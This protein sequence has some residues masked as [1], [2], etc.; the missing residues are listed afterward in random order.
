ML[1]KCVTLACE[2]ARAIWTYC[3]RRKAWPKGHTRSM[4]CFA[5]RLFVLPFGGAF[6]RPSESY[7]AAKTGEVSSSRH[8]EQFCK[9]TR[10]Q[11]RARL[12][13]A[14]GFR[15]AW[16]LVLAEE[17]R[18]RAMRVFAGAV[19]ALPLYCEFGRLVPNAS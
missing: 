16:A 15:R 8:S 2:V 7:A 11:R 12:F 5:Q 19:R 17:K 6:H 10:V 3:V 9:S 4:A 18:M 13:L 14:C 1:A